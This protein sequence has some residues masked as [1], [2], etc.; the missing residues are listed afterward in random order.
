VQRVVNAFVRAARFG[1]DEANRRAVFDFWAK[2]GY[3][4]AA[5]AEDLRQA[6]W[7]AIETASADAKKIESVATQKTIEGVKEAASVATA[8]FEQAQ[9]QM[10]EG[11]Q[12]A[13]KTAE[14]VAQ[15]SQGNV[16][17]FVKSSQI[18]ASGWQDLSKL[19]AANAKAS[20]D[21]S[22]STFKALSSVKSLKEAFDLQTSFA[23][24]SLEKA[25]S[26]SGK[27]TEHSLKV[28]EQAFA[29]ISA[30]VNAAVET[31]SA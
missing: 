30:R 2:S 3:P 29:P 24:T 12:R 11:V 21:E 5:F 23:R 15:F 6:E 17:A 13:M 4:P 10:K 1:A 28:A 8:G 19:F 27:I 31:F 25:V 20:L 14:Q 26:E 7:E 16:E 22:I 9:V 18:L